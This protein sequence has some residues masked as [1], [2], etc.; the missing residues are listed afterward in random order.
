[1]T[2]PQ[3]P[4]PE[5]VRIVNRIMEAMAMSEAT[6]RFRRLFEANGR[7]LMA[8]TVGSLNTLGLSVN[9]PDHLARQIIA[10]GGSNL[11]G[12]DIEGQT[13]RALFRGLAESRAQG[14]APSSAATR[15]L[16]G[17]HV[18]EGRFVN[19]GPKYRARL[20]ARTETMVAQNESTLAAYEGTTAVQA[21]EAV[22]DQVGHGDA[23]CS[24]RNG[25]V[26]S[27][28]EAR[29]IQDHPNGTLRWLPITR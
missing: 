21:V 18:T 29:G 16:I 28:A 27:I 5:D 20:I 22:D 19:A 15:R 6:E 3:L 24:V 25:E 1:M 14:L 2:T 17:Q 13:R 26:Y 10:R 23:P 11:L 8:S 9:I 12:M 7:R 4:D